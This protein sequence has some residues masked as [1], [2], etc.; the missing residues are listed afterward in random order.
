M[1]GRPGGVHPGHV[2]A[3]SSPLPLS[4][5]DRNVLPLHSAFRPIQ[6]CNRG[7]SLPTIDCMKRR[8][9]LLILGFWTLLG[10]LESSKTYV[11]YR[12]HDIP[13]GWSEALIG[14]MPWWYVWALLT[15]FAFALAH[16]FRFDE[17]H[18][19]VAG[20]EIGRAHV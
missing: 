15:P 17:S 7:S 1:P 10:L 19:V 5:P 14:N 6:P 20:L 13:W 12:V 4:T 16:R 2:T 11:W 18:R 3:A 8:D 9:R